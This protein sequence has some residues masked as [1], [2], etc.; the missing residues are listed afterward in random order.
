[1]GFSDPITAGNVLIRPAIQSP[2]YVAGVSGWTINR[3]GSAEFN[4]VT[5]RGAFVVANGTQ[6]ISVFNNTAPS[7][8]P[9][10][11]LNP[12]TAAFFAAVM[13]AGIDPGDAN[14]GFLFLQ[15]PQAI[16]TGVP[17]TIQMYDNTGLNVNR[18]ISM[19]AEIVRAS[20]FF[21]EGSATRSLATSPSATV[22][23]GNQTTLVSV[24][25]QA[26]A[27]AYYAVEASWDGFI[28]VG[29]AAFPG[30][31]VTMVINQAGTKIR[32]QRQ[33]LGATTLLQQGGCF[34]T[35]A[36]AAANGSLTFDLILVHEAT[37]TATNV[38]VNGSGTSPISLAVHGYQF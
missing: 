34:E 38:Q 3:N 16:S 27:N 19:D 23:P 24:T 2:N 17:S 33:L 11:N 18:S 4:S 35:K 30:N 15:S 12:N 32:G 13:W 8:G 25:I 9:S 22:T 14:H 28:L 36:Q 26:I 29:P 1:M 21:Y 5:V 37:S 10:V 7:L 20:Q 6:Q 31:R